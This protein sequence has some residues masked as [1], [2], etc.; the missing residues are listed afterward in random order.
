M[1]AVVP[2]DAWS[3]RSTSPIPGP[4]PGTP[5]SQRGTSPLPSRPGTP[6]G[7]TMY[8]RPASPTYG[9]SMSPPPLSGGRLGS[10]SPSPEPPLMGPDFGALMPFSQSW[11]QQ[12]FS[13]SQNPYGAAPPTV[14]P[15]AAQTYAPP[16][17]PT[18][19]GP[20]NPSA[21]GAL[22]PY[23][24]TSATSGGPAYG[25]VQNPYGA[26]AAGYEP[27]AQAGTAYSASKAAQPPPLFTN[28]R[29]TKITM[30]QLQLNQPGYTVDHS[31]G[32]IFYGNEVKHHRPNGALPKRA[33]AYEQR[34]FTPWPSFPN[35]E[36]Q[37]VSDF[38][39]YQTTNVSGSWQ[40]KGI[41][42]SIF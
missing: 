9:R 24:A 5:L 2:F 36:V 27:A 21:Y 1:A 3:V 31:M 12:Q 38:L 25:S 26:P 23:T 15:A 17:A 41:L 13:Q 39:R 33:H 11:A 29:N 16:A 20:T 32:R 8:A 40:A 34:Q 7:P 10:P 42:N 22:Q 28:S 35:P 19:A 37:S 6:L 4:R 18:Y 14:T 30:G